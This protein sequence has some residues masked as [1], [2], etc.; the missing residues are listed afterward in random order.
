[1]KLNDIITEGKG[2]PQKPKPYKGNPVAKNI[3]KFN[4]PVTHRDKKKEL[5]R[6]GPDFKSYDM[7]EA[8]TLVSDKSHIIDS[9]LNKIK[10]K[11][12]KDDSMI[13]RLASLIHSTAS[14]RYDSNPKGSWEITPNDKLGKNDWEPMKEQEI[15]DKEFKATLS[16]KHKK[17]MNK[18]DK[19]QTSPVDAFDNM[20][21]VDGQPEPH[22]DS[23]N[24]EKQVLDALKNKKTMEMLDNLTDREKEVIIWR[25][26]LGGGKDYTLGDIGKM[27]G[28][29]RER[30]RQIEARALRKLRHPDRHSEITAEHVK[31]GLDSYYQLTKAKALAKADGHD[32]DKLPEY[33]RGKDQPHKE[34]YKALA[35]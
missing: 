20:K 15:D 16:K 19:N 27:L 14:I 9:I 6:K 35:K 32:Y 17:F 1:M 4:R 28:L 23:G 34:K 31:G 13:K 18:F 11:A 21:R 10:E 7:D 29:L 2:I 30:V 33:H 22:S 26:G 5:K 8:T 12:M 24:P 25:Y 3:E